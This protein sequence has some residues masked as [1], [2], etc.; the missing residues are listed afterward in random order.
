MNNQFTLD[1]WKGE[2]TVSG[3]YWGDLRKKCCL[4]YNQLGN[5][6]FIQ[7]EPEFKREHYEIHTKG[8]VTSIVCD[9]FDE[10]IKFAMSKQC[11]FLS[12]HID[13]R[14]KGTKQIIIKDK[15]NEMKIFK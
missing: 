12:V 13:L 15:K 1:K 10:F 8:S 3:H 11:N 5:H 4:A 7:V 9:K 6:A 2:K 14:E